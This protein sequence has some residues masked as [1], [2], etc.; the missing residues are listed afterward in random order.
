MNLDFD[1]LFSPLSKEYCTYFYILSMF[2]YVLLVIFILL[3]LGYLIKNFNNLKDIK[4]VLLIYGIQVI[5]SLF[6]SYFVNR[7]L[8][9][10]CVNSLH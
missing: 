9:S 8:Y 5:V 3:S 6:L 4:F 2:F 10:I 7:L 1:Y